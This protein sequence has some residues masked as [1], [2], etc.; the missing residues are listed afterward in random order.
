MDPTFGQRFTDVL[1]TLVTFAIVALVIALVLR[2]LRRSRPELEIGIPISVALALRVV[3][4]M[5]VSLTGVGS[6]LRGGDELAFL[7]KA[8]VVTRSAFGSSDWTHAL[9]NDL[10]VFVIAVQRAALDSPDMALRVTESGIAVCGLA[11][12]ATAVFDLAGKRAALVAAWLL[13]VE[14]GGAFFSALI[15]K[16][17]LMF[18]AIGLVSLGAARMWVRG[19][20]RALIPMAGGCLVAAATR[21]YAGWF[22]IA[23]CAAITL[24][25]GLRGA[26]E[27]SARSMIAVA[28]TVLAASLILP[29]VFGSFASQN[30]EQLSVSQ[31][32]NAQDQSNLQ[33]EAVNFSSG[34]GIATG[35]PLRIRDLLVRPYPWQLG[36][37]SQQLGL[38]GTLAALAILALLAR[39]L[40]RGRGHIFR[41]AGPLLYIGTSLMIAYALTVGNAGTGF[42]Y[43]TQVLAIFIG[44]ILVLAFSPERR[45]RSVADPPQHVD[46]GAAPVPTR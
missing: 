37:T 27:G 18:L 4:A 23:A 28:A 1:T 5:I 16:E 45:A 34:T 30:L 41:R 11:L 46:L 33:L 26:R 35:L 6:S 17:A 25:A 24:H 7:F 3:G 15:H 44:A 10:H 8:D 29:V 14:P 42:R 31:S 38:L 39:E 9:T 43:R 19:E 22:L 32:A 36:N 13:A 12:L 2:A 21:G 40:W 20:Y